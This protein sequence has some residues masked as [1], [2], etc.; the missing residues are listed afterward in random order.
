MTPDLNFEVAVLPDR[1][2]YYKFY[3]ISVSSDIKKRIIRK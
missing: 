2:V 1:Y 3:P